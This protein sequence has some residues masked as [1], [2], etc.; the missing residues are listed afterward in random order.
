M[1]GRRKKGL[2]Q[3]AAEIFAQCQNVFPNWATLSMDDFTFDDPK[4]FSSFTMGIQ[5]KTAADPPAVLYRRLAGKE[6]AILDYEVE[7]N[8]FLMLSTHKIAAHCYHYEPSCRI[9]AFYQ[10]RTLQASDLFDPENLRKIANELYKF[11]QL[12]PPKLPQDIFFE[13][14]FEKWG[15]LAKNV[16][17]NNINAF[18]PHERHMAE[19]LR[20][21]YSL[22]TFEKVKQ[23]LPGGDMIFCHNDTYHGNIMKLDNG[24]IKLLDFEFSCLNHRTYDFSNLFAETVMQHQ[25]P[26]YPFFR[27]AEPEFGDDEIGLL[28]NFYLDNA[29]FTTPTARENEY[30]KLLQ[31][32]KNMLKMSDF[33][34]AMAALPLAL[35]PIQKIRF[36]PYAYQRFSKFMKALELSNG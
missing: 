29:T 28:I 9:E 22:E 35:E 20:Q 5:A 6:N 11:H 17:E 18:P 19:E 15:V 31:E 1:F 24:D 32:T 25:Q 26:N 8:V 33:K 30:E 36:I 23:C 10:G 16:L 12:Q 14:L 7:K 4:G 34:Y 3:I 13:L 27:I 2:S 21:I